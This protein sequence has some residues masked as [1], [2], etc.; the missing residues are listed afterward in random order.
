MRLR[1]AA[2]GAVAAV[3]AG[4]AS[5]ATAQS[6]AFTYQGQLLEA[7][8]P[9]TGPYD[10]WFRLYDQPTN[11][12]D[13]GGMC[14]DGIEVSG[15]TFSVTLDFG[16]LLSTALPRYLEIQVRAEDG[17]VCGV[18]TG[19]T[20]MTPRQLV[21]PAPLAIHSQTSANASV[22]AHAFTASLAATANS[23]TPQ[24][25]SP[26][27]A[28]FVDNE[29]RVGMGTTAPAA[30]LHVMAP[31]TGLAPG[32]GVRIQGALSTAANMAF[33]NFVNGAGTAIGYVGDGSTG[34]QSIY[35]GA[36]LGDVALVTSGGQVVTATAGGNLGV[37]TATPGAKLDVR[38]D[39]KLG[40]AGTF[41]AVKSLVND[42]TLRGQVNAAGTIDAGRSSGGFTITHTTTGTYV[43][44]FSSAF[45]QAPTCVATGMAACCT[46]K[47]TQTQTTFAT[48]HV[49]DETGTFTDAPF[50]FI[51]MGP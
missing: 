16:T 36:Y 19:Y 4:L 28:V 14:L 34:N 20:T 43:I 15:G 32:E 26:V 30:P 8:V 13:L 41:F 44:N 11:G 40:S 10:M 23:L 47:V 22:A 24:D 42:R 48:V 7:G 18:P 17:S 25:G 50:H 33:V 3:L 51:V 31:S 12:S 45:S 29:G 49:R 35:V 2:I 46:P 5:E 1:P 9:A 27:N 39:I 38:G 21:T 6:T 37:G